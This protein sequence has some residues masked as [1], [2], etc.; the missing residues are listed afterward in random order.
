MLVGAW[1]REW[2]ASRGRR[3]AAEQF[4]QS[5][6]YAILVAFRFRMN[7]PLSPFTIHNPQSTHNPQSHNHTAV[8]STY[9]HTWYIHSSS[10]ANFSATADS[11][12][13]SYPSSSCRRLGHADRSQGTASFSN[14]LGLQLSQITRPRRVWI[15]ILIYCLT[16]VMSVVMPTPWPNHYLSLG[17]PGRYGTRSQ[18]YSYD[19]KVCVN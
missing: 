2:T 5:Q 9:Q 1:C 6:K 19:W 15:R 16:S 3:S 7:G 13:R 8:H 14:T 4:R 18:A 11:G 12:S 10:S 17:R